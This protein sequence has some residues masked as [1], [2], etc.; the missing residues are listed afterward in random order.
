MSPIPPS[1]RRSHAQTADSRASEPQ[2]D[3][4][5]EA[6]PDPAPSSS[7]WNRF[8]LVAGGSYNFS[9]KVY[10]D[11]SAYER[12]APGHTGAQ[13][14][15]QPGFSVLSRENADVRVGLHYGH[16][17]LSSSRSYNGNSAFQ[18]IELGAFAEG[19]YIPH[20]QF[21]IGL[22]GRLSYSALSANSV[23]VGLPVTANF[24]FPSDGS[25]GLGASIFL[26]TWNQALRLGASL[27]TVSTGITLS[28]PPPNAPLPV[29]VS[30]VWAVFSAVDVFQ[31]IRNF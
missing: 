15:I 24:G 2:E 20:P 8:H 17:F 11:S 10:A 29:Q 3:P 27:D 5:V 23:D 28:M 31:V 22:Q 9:T 19:A 13:F 4:S 30:P 16:H 7:L 14:F 18:I 26:T 1:S 6:V 12:A 25:I 21:G